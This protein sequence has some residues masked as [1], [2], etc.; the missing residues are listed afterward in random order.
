MPTINNMLLNIPG[1]ERTNSS[2]GI[3]VNDGKAVKG[4]SFGEVL[5]EQIQE[6]S[7]EMVEADQMGQDLISGR[8][9]NI[10]ETM[11]ALS[12]ADISFRLLLR[13]RNKAVEAYQEIMR[14]QV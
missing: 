3:N 2:S 8:S 14:T 7:N 10:H 4:Q 1:V 11:L 13:V 5:Q 9:N 6:V 12:K